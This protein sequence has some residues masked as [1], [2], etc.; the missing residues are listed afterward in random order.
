VQHLAGLAPVATITA[1][2]TAGEGK[3][4]Q[5]GDVLIK[6][7]D[8]EYP[9]VVQTMQQVRARKG[10]TVAMRVLRQQADGTLAA[11]DL[12]AV[13]VGSKGQVGV[14]LGD[15]S[16]TSAVVASPIV[17]M[18]TP[19]LKPYD[20]SAATAV[21]TAGS[22]IVSVNDQPVQTLREVA[23]H[24]HTLAR[25]T[26]VDQSATVHLGFRRPAAGSV[27]ATGP[28]ESVTITLNPTDLA[29]LRLLSYEATSMALAFEPQDFILKASNPGE[30]LAFGFAET[31]RVM[32][33]TYLTFAR[34]AQGTVKVEHLKGPVGIAHLG[35]LVA[36]K[37]FIWLLFFL[38]LISVNLAVINFLPLPIVD[39]GQFLFLVYEAV[40]GKP[41]P[42]AVQ[43]GVTMVGLVLIGGI[44][45][46][47]TFNDIRNLLG[48]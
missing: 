15:S 6:V 46:L 2:A 26:P 31:K 20:T 27:D 17:V 18:H 24:L 35:T 9:S 29:E 10:S 40:R 7:G 22:R 47:V 34:L 42:I 41:V 3:G 39:G 36:G 28:Q 4:L 19:A 38:A 44:F 48:L 11:I 43:N 45:L 32:A 23:A 8:V 12:P 30:A 21:I 13:K 5:A 14:G 16:S 25:T 37:G 1:V 33:M